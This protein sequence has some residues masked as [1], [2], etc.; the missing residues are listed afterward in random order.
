MQREIVEGAQQARVGDG[1]FTKKCR[2]ASSIGPFERVNDVNNPSI[3][4]D[5]R[6]VAGLVRIQR[7]RGLECVDG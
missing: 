7:V 6:V 5:E 2:I 3:Q 4:S 1:P